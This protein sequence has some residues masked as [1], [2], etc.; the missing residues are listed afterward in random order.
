MKDHQNQYPQHRHSHDH[1]LR[2]HDAEMRDSVVATMTVS[3]ETRSENTVENAEVRKDL[4]SVGEVALPAD[5]SGAT[6]LEGP[7][8]PELEEDDN[9][10][11]IHQIKIVPKLNVFLR[12]F[13][14]PVLRNIVDIGKLSVGDTIYNLRNPL[15]KAKV[16]SGKAQTQE[17]GILRQP[18]ARLFKHLN[19]VINNNYVVVGDLVG[20]QKY[21]SKVFYDVNRTIAEKLYSDNSVLVGTDGETVDLFDMVVADVDMR[22]VTD[23]VV[24]HI[25]GVATVCLNISLDIQVPALM[26]SPVGAEKVIQL[27]AK[28]LTS[29]AERAGIDWVRIGVVFDVANFTTNTGEAFESFDTFRILVSNEGANKVERIVSAVSNL[30]YMFATNTG[31]NTI[32]FLAGNPKP[33]ENESENE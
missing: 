32:V 9:K 29:A 21:M 25:E 1:D 17:I 2:T 14:S 7:E 22:A 5:E 16:V 19:T 18:V 8:L 24:E 27:Y 33:N 11:V 28:F 30:D 20:V 6:E 10:L 12:C 26:A 3:E 31:G 23:D 4:E 15:S 13:D